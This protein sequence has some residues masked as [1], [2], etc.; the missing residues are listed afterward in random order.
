MNMDL[1]SKIEKD[2]N[3]FK[4]TSKAPPV[5]VPSNTEHEVISLFS[6]PSIKYILFIVAA[7]ALMFGLWFLWD[8]YKEHRLKEKKEKEDKETKGSGSGTGS[9]SG[10]GSGSGTG[11]GSGSGSGTGSGSSSGSGTGSGS[12]SGSSAVIPP[13]PPVSSPE[14]QAQYARYQQSQQALHDAL[15]PNA[16]Q[17]GCSIEGDSA[18]SSIQ[19]SKTTGKSGWCYIGEDRGYASCASVGTND[20]CMSGQVFP[21]EAACR[22]L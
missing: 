14:Q 9:G 20:Q 1:S 3:H 8:W 7:I 19:Q 11:I 4:S 13:P 2:I 18:G 5:P 22:Q 16:Y 12:S 15:S 17:G 21:T 10:S 6:S